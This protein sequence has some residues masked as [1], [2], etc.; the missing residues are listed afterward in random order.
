MC[1]FYN[2]NSRLLEL[3]GI[4]VLTIDRQ[5]KQVLNI[6]N[7]L[8]NWRMGQ[9]PHCGSEFFRDESAKIIYRLDV[10]LFVRHDST[11]FHMGFAGFKLR[12]EQCDDVNIV[13]S[14]QLSVV[15]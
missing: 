13:I 2:L 11:F 14:Y 6:S 3:T 10:Y 5:P 4:H 1:S 7:V 12:F 15:S 8:V 9:T